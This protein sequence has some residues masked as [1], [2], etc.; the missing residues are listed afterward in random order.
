MNDRWKEIPGRP[1]YYERIG[2]FNPPT[3]LTPMARQMIA[4]VLAH[5]RASVSTPGSSDA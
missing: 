2:E 3:E 5:S 1:G 4:D